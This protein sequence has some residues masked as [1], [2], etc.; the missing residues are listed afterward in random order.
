VGWPQR[1]ARFER[2]AKTIAGLNRPHSCTLHDV[3][4]HEGSTLLSVI[5]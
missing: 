3:G 1:R 2:E 4:G 5:A